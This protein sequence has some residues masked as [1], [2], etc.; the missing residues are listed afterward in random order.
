[1]ENLQIIKNDK[2]HSYEFGKASARHKIYYNSVDELI[3]HIEKLK[4]L[5]LVDKE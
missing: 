3:L 1:M 5:G 4:N 2:P